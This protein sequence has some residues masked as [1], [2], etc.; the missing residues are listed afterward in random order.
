MPAVSS[1]RPLS[2]ALLCIAAFVI[3]AGGLTAAEGS[4]AGAA[5]ATPHFA[6][7]GSNRSEATTSATESVPVFVVPYRPAG[8]PQDDDQIQFEREQLLRDWMEQ[9]VE[10]QPIYF[11]PAPPVLGAPLPGGGLFADDVV[12]ALAPYVNELF[13]APLSTRLAEEDLGRRSRARLGAYREHKAAE[14]RELRATL[15]AVRS[16]SP[17]DR[18]DALE[19]LAQEQDPGLL[20][21]ERTADDLR[22]ELFRQRFLGGGGDWS[23]YRAWRLEATEPARLR[24]E[25]RLREMRVLRAAVYYQ[26]G[27]SAPQRRLLRE[28]VMDQAAALHVPGAGVGLPPGETARTI[29]FSPDTARVALPATLP[30]GLEKLISEY[31]AAKDALKQELRDRLVA[32]DADRNATRRQR[33]LQDLAGEQTARI[34]GLEELAERIREQLVPFAVSLAPPAPPTLPGA[35]EGRVAAYLRDK[36]DLQRIAQERLAA[37]LGDF[38]RTEKE[39]EEEQ[40]PERR[41]TVVRATVEAFHADHAERIA[42]LNAEADA[43]RGELARH[44]AAAPGRENHKSIDALL[45]EFADAFK[46]QQLATVYAEYRTA[47]LEPGLSAAQRRL[48]F[49]GAVAEMKLP[50]AIHDR[51]VAPDETLSRP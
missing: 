14:L 1:H 5:S 43:I 17:S 39:A 16:A 31:V 34:A 50:G 20:A 10:P 40:R 37:A 26:E 2:R 8:G 9:P 12:R 46:R 13:Y 18:R 32:L 30:P 24:P 45:L 38:D 47:V 44:A 25:I 36:S 51:Q 7:P 48:L 6:D 35:L 33:A 29:F 15:E 27:L 3:G 22:R 23:Q 49:D 28:V 4:G 41:A 11:P 21:L 42:A 19:R